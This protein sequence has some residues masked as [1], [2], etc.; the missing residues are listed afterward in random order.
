M[1]VVTVE[2]DCIDCGGEG[3]T[4]PYGPNGY[5]AQEKCVTCNGMKKIKVDAEF[6]RMMEGS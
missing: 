4:V 3:W 2:I 1:S 5:E 6:A